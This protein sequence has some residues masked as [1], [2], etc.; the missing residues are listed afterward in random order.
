MKKRKIII[1]LSA[2]GVISVIIGGIL[3]KKN[4][5]L[6][7][8][9]IK[10][11]DATYSCNKESEKFYEDNKYIYYFSCKKSNSIYVKF[12]NGDKKLVVTA[13]E[14]ELVTIDELIKAGLEV[15]KKEK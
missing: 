10:I 12:P 1:V 8:N 2:L 9:Q 7:K 11:L 14:E 5:E 6:E 13:L 3:L 4:I 15:H